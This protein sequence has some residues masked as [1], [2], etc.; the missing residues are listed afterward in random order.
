MPNQPS[1]LGWLADGTMLVVSMV[2][3]K[4]L[5]LDGRHAA[6]S[7]PISRR[8]RRR[9]A[10]TWSST[11]RGRAYVGNFGFDM[12]GGEPWRKTNLIAVE[13]DGR[14]WIAADEI[15]FPNGPVITPDG[16]TLI[17]GESTA[18]RL[19]AF[20]I[21]DDGTLSNRRVWASLREIGATPDGICLDADGAIWVACPATD[22]CVRVAEGGDA[23][24]RGRDRA[25]HVRVRARRAATVARCSSAR[26]TRTSPTLHARALQRPHRD[27]RRRRRRVPERRRTFVAVRARTAG[28]R[29][30]RAA[31]R[32]CPASRPSSP[33]RRSAPSNRRPAGRRAPRRR[34][35]RGRRGSGRRRPAACAAA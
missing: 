16:R 3:R 1:G 13:P 2:D 9:T 28:R 18:A 8:S 22:R 26:P 33:C 15:S 6:P 20:D 29:S 35:R 30:P 10:T 31:L 17:V 21:A 7:T 24:R 34:P 27:R 19:T 25:R 5:R 12:Y 23:P 14:A 32:P 11:R 4:V